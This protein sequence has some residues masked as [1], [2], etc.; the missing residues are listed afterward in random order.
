MF[1]IAAETSEESSGNIQAKSGSYRPMLERLK[2]GLRIADTRAG[3]LKSDDDL[4]L[5]ERNADPQFPERT[6]FNSS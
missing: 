3:I 5:I 2:K 6:L 4:L 1:E